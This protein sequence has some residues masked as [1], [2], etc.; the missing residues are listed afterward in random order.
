[1]NK[2]VS[3]ML[4][5]L[6]G[7]LKHK[8]IPILV[9]LCV[10]SRCNLDCRYCYRE[11]NGKEF[12][13]QEILNLIDELADMGTQRIALSGGEALLR[14][15]IGVIVDRIK[16]K[17]ML[18]HLSTNGLL[19]NDNI[20]LLKKIDFLCVSID[21]IKESNDINRG[22]GS[23]IKV[24]KA[25]ECLNNNNISFFTHT[26]LTKNNKNAVDEM[27]SLSSKYGFKVQFSILRPIDS[28]E[29]TIGLSDSEIKKSI[30]KILDYKKAGMPIFFSSGAYKNTLN[31]PFSYEKQMVYSEESYKGIKCYLK[32]FMCQIE[33]SGLVYPC[34]VLVNKFK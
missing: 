19:V 24:I 3:Y 28:P 17:K 22:K 31:W 1:M 26:V 34:I 11:K 6:E 29:K 32:R 25:I 30:S 18:C 23:Y 27:L 15:D 33:P 7:R 4:K 2:Y 16:Q 13:L 21:G 10:T 20:S 5:V 14:K 8:N 12:T 9:T